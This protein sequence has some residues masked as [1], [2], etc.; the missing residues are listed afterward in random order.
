MQNI[1]CCHKFCISCEA[2]TRRNFKIRNLLALYIQF[3]NQT[4][5][6]KENK[7]NSSL[8]INPT[9]S[10]VLFP[11]TSSVQLLLPLVKPSLRPHGSFSALLSDFPVDFEQVLPVP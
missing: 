11:V 8:Y 5:I 7:Y 1:T 2:V 3:A 9:G 6:V 10:C 4:P